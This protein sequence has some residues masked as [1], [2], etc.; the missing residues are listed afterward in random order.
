MNEDWILGRSFYQSRN[1]LF[2]YQLKQVH[3]YSNIGVSPEH[4]AIEDD[5]N[6]NNR[7]NKVIYIDILFI[8]IIEIANEIYIKLTNH[9]L[10][11]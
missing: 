11:K 9:L 6:N 4:M 2:D 8:S 7:Y 3:M 5:S 10:H 1:I